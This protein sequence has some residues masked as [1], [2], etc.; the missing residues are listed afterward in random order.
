MQA[1]VIYSRVKV[2]KNEDQRKIDFGDGFV[3]PVFFQKFGI[4]R[5][6]NER[7]VCVKYEAEKAGRHIRSKS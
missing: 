5:M 3:Q 2:L 1:N 6:T 4:L 7:Q